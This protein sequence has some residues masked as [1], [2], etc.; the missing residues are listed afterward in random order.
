M[1]IRERYTP[2]TP[3]WPELSSSDQAGAKAFYAAL[4]GWE[5]QDLPMGD[6]GVYSMLQLD[7]R[8]A[9]A[10]APQPPQQRDAGVPSMWNT[11]ITVESADAALAQAAELGGTVHA[12][13][14]D[15]MDAGRMGIV[16]DPFGAFFE[17]WEPR[18]RIGAEVVNAP[19]AFSWCE[20]VTPAIEAATEFYRGL[21]GWTVTPFEGMAVP[22][23]VLATADGHTIGGLRPATE[24]EPPHWL[25][26]FGCGAIEPA[27]ARVEE[28]GGRGLSGPHDIGV[29]KLATVADPQ[30]AVFALYD[31]RFDD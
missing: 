1:G 19:G 15:V 13:A 25:V 12:D 29:G 31:G 7:G 20:L 26:Y 16:Q 11:Y 18:A 22:Y 30:G 17:V 10:I 28:L 5:V 21:F 4:F 9:G 14:F 6:A 24:A 27:M 23:S 2:G 3:S 8:S